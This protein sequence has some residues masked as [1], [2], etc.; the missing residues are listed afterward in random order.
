[1]IQM[2]ILHVDQPEL[3]ISLNQAACFAFRYMIAATKV[4]IDRGA[5]IFSIAAPY[6]APSTLGSESFKRSPISPNCKNEV[7]GASGWSS[8]LPAYH[9]L[10]EHSL[11][12]SKLQSCKIGLQTVLVDVCNMQLCFSGL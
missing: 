8:I 7:N 11:A 1:M 3:P 4:K 5:A 10:I 9:A 12:Q 2:Y 6:F